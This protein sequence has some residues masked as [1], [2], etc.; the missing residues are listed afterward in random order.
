MGKFHWCGGTVFQV[1]PTTITQ[2]YLSFFVTKASK[3]KLLLVSFYST[4]DGSYWEDK[5]GSG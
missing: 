1:Y 2:T 3:S 4:N 5:T